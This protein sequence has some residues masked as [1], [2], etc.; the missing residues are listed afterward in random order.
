MTPLGFHK[1]GMQACAL[2]LAVA[3]LGNGLALLNGVY[4]TTVSMILPFIFVLSI[5]F[6]LLFI[7]ITIN[8]QGSA[9]RTALKV[10]RVE[11]VSLV[12][13]F[14]FIAFQYNFEIQSYAATLF[15]GVLIT[16]A[17]LLYMTLGLFFGYNS[18]QQK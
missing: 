18:D 17:F 9:G 5:S 4:H 15:I 13:M 10:L 12:A 2:I 16:I 14:V 6:V 1:I 7:L 3:M 8:F 11:C